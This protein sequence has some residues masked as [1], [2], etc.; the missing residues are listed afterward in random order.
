MLHLLPGK[1]S[2]SNLCLSSKFSHYSTSAT[3]YCRSE[4]QLTQDFVTISL[5]CFDFYTLRVDTVIFRI[6]MNK[7]F[8]I[9]SHAPS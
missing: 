3:Y 5:I 8:C 4:V 7:V 9:L 6:G 1:F 2:L